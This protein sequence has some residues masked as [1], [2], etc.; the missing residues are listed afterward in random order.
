MSKHAGLCVFKGG[1]SSGFFPA[2][3]VESSSKSL[4]ELS[5]LPGVDDDVSAGVQHQQQVRGQ[6]QQARPANIN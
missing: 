2:L 4:P 1:P 5:I 6:G 3:P